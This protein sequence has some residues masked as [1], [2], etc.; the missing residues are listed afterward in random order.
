MHDW[1]ISRQ[2]AW[3]IRIPVW[4]LI[5]GNEDKIWLS[6]IDKKVFLKGGINQT[7]S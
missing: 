6:F 7:I 5:N 3:G 4:Y 2:I 1:P